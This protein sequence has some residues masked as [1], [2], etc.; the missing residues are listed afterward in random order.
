MMS[1]TELNLNPNIS[2]G[3]QT[4]GY[5]TPTPIQSRSIPDILSGKDLVASAQTGTGKT[6]AF[7]LPALH[8]L[9]KTKT[10]SLKPRVLILTPT[11]ELATQIMDAI[12]KYGKFMRFNMV[13]LVGG[14]P[15]RQQLKG[16]ARPVD[17]IVATPGRLLDH[18]SNRRL[19]LSH[20][21][22]FILDEADRML[23]M[24]F[25]DD[26]KQIAKTMPATR[27]TLLF[28]ATVDDKLNHIIKQLL[29]NPVR[30]NLSNEKMS[31]IKIKQE[32]YM[33][34]NVQ[35]KLRLLQHFIKDGHLFKA[36]I[37]SATKVS[38]DKLTK[39][40]QS[41][42]HAVAAL[43]G[44][45]KQN[46]RN[47]TVEAMRRGKIQFLIATDVA[48]R[49]I[50]ISDV[51]HVINFDL[52]K[53][54]EDYVH[55]IGRTGRAG[56]S[57]T[58]ISF[59]LPDDGRHL[60]G[61]ER[62]I[63]EK[64]ILSTVAGLE[65]SKSFN[66]NATKKKRNRR[67]GGSRQPSDNSSGSRDNRSKKKEM[68]GN[69]WNHKSKE[70]KK[71]GFRNADSARSESAK[72]LNFRKDPMRRETSRSGNSKNEYARSENWRNRD[73]KNDTSRSGENSRKNRLRGDD[74]GHARKN[75]F[76]SENPRKE[77]F[78]NTNI[79]PKST[80]NWGAKTKSSPFKNDRF[81]TLA[82]TKKKDKK[83]A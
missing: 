20:I 39:Q 1:F 10:G 24:G 11:R 82:Q 80:N 74:T 48:A 55:R 78:R 5:T 73:S 23:D 63:G 9:S 43:H 47:R 64:I 25:I 60:Q 83:Y 40:L 62:Y 33:A 44:D 27:Q 7:V 56:K 6:A 70:V 52:P 17:I 54:H 29:K 77:N 68:K 18:M 76:K 79:K 15:Y 3:L 41:E 57:G 13:S 67:G 14:M 32:L 71:S 37:F 16:L 12:A 59:A 38:V 51:T 21:E 53:F 35:H 28:S 72:K 75:V 50:D 46:V 69:S 31:P 34:D 8:L 36:I 42:G 26:V 81:K 4:C 22:M 2:K 49:G 65:A 66:F 30:I 58:A 19:D 61:I 45:L